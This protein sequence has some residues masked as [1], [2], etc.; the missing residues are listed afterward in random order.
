MSEHVT[1]FASSCYYFL[2]NLRWIRKYLSQSVCETLVNALVVSRLDY[3]NSLLYGH[4]FKLLSR[5]QR[6]QN[7]AARLIYLSTRYSPSS[8]LLYHLHCLPIKYR[9]IFKI[10]LI[11]FK[12]IHGLAPSY[13]QDL[14]KVQHQSRVLRFAS[15]TSLEH[16]SIKS[17]NTLGDRSFFLAA[18]TEWN[19]LP[20]NIRNSSSLAIFK[21]LQKFEHLRMEFAL[22][23]FILLLLLLL[24]LLS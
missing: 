8:P 5:L 19:R 24:L 9:C 3:C 7:S 16:P 14:V 12:A 20:A 10:F 21:R 13:I 17:S 22:F 18:P 2:Y 11:T 4:P 23:Q 15:A 1:R 6:V